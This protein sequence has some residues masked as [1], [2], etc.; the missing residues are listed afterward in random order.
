M[1]IDDLRPVARHIL[2]LHAREK[3]AAQLAACYE[4][5]SE[6]YRH[7]ANKARW[8]RATGWDAMLT[9]EEEEVIA[10]A[11][12]D[13]YAML[14]EEVLDPDWRASPGVVDGPAPVGPPNL[15]AALDDALTVVR[16][17][18]YIPMAAEVGPVQVQVQV[19]P[20]SYRDNLKVEQLR[21]ERQYAYG[22]S[23]RHVLPIGSGV[24][25]IIIADAT[26]PDPA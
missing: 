2:R 21:F 14:A 26:A 1:T 5:E 25:V 7:E 15:R 12:E 9:Y 11:L 17:H 18:G 24:T 19:T 4:E 3:N 22:D 20:A 10:A 6:H 16:E 8:D 13:N 23:V